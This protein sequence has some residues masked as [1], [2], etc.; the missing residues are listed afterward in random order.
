MIDERFV[1]H[2]FDGNKATVSKDQWLDS[3]SGKKSLFGN[4]LLAEQFRSRK[5]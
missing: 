3:I 2:V 5:K 4:N 1:D